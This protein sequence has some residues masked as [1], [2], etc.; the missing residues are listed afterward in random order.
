ML[1]LCCA[2]AV[3]VSLIALV[4]SLKVVNAVGPFAA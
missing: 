2:S 1:L 3:L 4:A